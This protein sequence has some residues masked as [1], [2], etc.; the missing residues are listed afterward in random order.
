VAFVNS[1][2]LFGRL[3][4]A[5]VRFAWRFAL[6]D[7]ATTRR[8]DDTTTRRKNMIFVSQFARPFCWR[9]TGR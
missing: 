9:R 6:H 7:D 1:Q 3:P 8:R 5:S 2:G 4:P